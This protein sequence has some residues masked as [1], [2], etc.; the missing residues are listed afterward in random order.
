L[1]IGIDRFHGI[2]GGS[3]IGKAVSPAGIGDDQIAAADEAR[4]DKKN[5]EV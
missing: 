4:E 3:K 1:K 5:S 2:P